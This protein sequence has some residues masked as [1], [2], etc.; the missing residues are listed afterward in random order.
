MATVCFVDCFP[1]GGEAVVW[2]KMSREDL[3]HLLRTLDVERCGELRLEDGEFSYSAIL[4]RHRITGQTRLM[5]LQFRTQAGFRP[6]WRHEG[7]QLV[8]GLVA[9]E[10]HPVWSEAARATPSRLAKLRR[11]L[12]L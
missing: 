9:D 3:R 12:G 7:T 4:Q 8:V 10:S 1:D 11:I 2:R 5:P 6:V